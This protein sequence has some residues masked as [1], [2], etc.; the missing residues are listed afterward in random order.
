[1]VK[2]MLPELVRLKL[3]FK[4]TNNEVI[5]SISA[6]RTEAEQERLGIDN[7]EAE[8]LIRNVQTGRLL[9]QDV[10]GFIIWEKDYRVLRNLGIVDLLW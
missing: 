10:S 5:T 7:R 2:S 6:L 1:M 4:E 3:V 9:S 8:K